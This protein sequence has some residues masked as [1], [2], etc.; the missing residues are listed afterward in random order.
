MV[1]NYSKISSDSIGSEPTPDQ[2][3]LWNKVSKLLL[4]MILRLTMV[5]CAVFN[6]SNFSRGKNLMKKFE[7]RGYAQLILKT[8]SN[9]LLNSRSL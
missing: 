4:R 5:Y 2:S 7:A 8:P 3:L 1:N 6:G 9:S